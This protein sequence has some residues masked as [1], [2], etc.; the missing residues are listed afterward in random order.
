MP[1]KDLLEVIEE[2]REESNKILGAVFADSN[3]LVAVESHE[4]TEYLHREGAKISVSFENGLKVYTKIPEK[5]QTSRV[6]S[7]GAVDSRPV[8]VID[9]QYSQREVVELLLTS[10]TKAILTNMIER[11]KGEQ[12]KSLT[13]SGG[14]VEKNI[15]IIVKNWTLQTQIDYLE[16]VLKKLDK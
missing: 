8:T 7:E 12:E 15:G 9:K 4:E 3:K 10:H 13:D 6:V 2:G 5:Y 11:M 14:S 1:T 16:K